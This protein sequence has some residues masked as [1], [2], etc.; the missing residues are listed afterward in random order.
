MT[1]NTEF[2][3]RKEASKILKV[4]MRTLD[5]YIKSNKIFA[6]EIDGRILLRVGDLKT[7]SKTKNT[8]S[9]TQNTTSQKTILQVDNSRQGSRQ[10]IA[11]ESRQNIAQESRQNSRQ[12]S[13]QGSR[14]NDKKNNTEDYQIELLK[15]QLEENIELHQNK[16]KNYLQELTNFKLKLSTNSRKRKYDKILKTF[17][18]FIILLLI[19]LQPLWL[20]FIYK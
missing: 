14:Q 10:N 17:Y 3:S 16:E 19:S 13:R 20:F 11:Q 12:D 2:V 15:K 1:K 8:T 7:F 4:S 18:I 9:Q 6:Q 5:R